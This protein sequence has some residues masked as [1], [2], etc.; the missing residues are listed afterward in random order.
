M[1]PEK[2][3]R[4]AHSV[5]SVGH[6]SLF[7][8]RVKH[9]GQI[10]ERASNLAQLDGNKIGADARQNRRQTTQNNLINK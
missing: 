9:M 4:H 1:V 7:N 8:D 5:E 2:N 6:L 3:Q 10:S